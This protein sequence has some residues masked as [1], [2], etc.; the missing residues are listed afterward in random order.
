M[1]FSIFLS[2]VSA[3]TCMSLGSN[4]NE[5]LLNDTY[6]HFCEGNFS[7]FR[8]FVNCY[9]SANS[10][11]S[12][13]SFFCFTF[14]EKNNDFFFGRCPLVSHGFSGINLPSQISSPATFNENIMCKAQNRAGQ[15]CSKC[16]KG[17]AL[18]LN[19][20]MFNCVP[21]KLCHKYNWLIFII[22]HIAPVTLL[23]V[24][25]V[26]FE[27][28]LLS[29][30]AFA[31]IL[32]SQ[33]ICLQP[34]DQQNT[35]GLS[36]TPEL[37]LKI[38]YFL[39]TF[40][41]IWTMDTGRMIYSKDLCTRDNID[42][43]G[44]LMLQLLPVFYSFFLIFLT[45]VCILVCQKCH[46]ATQICKPLS[47]CFSR[48]SAKRMNFNLLLVNVFAAFYVL[49]YAKVLT[50]CLML[51]SPTYLY[52]LE[53]DRYQSVYLY[54][55]SSSYFSG[56]RLIVL[57]TFALL[58]LIVIVIFPTI[59]L[60]LYQWKKFRKTFKLDKPCFITLMDSFQQCYKDGTNGTKDCRWFSAVYFLLRIVLFTLYLMLENIFFYKY[61]M[62]LL[63]QGCLIVTVILI[64]F[65]S[66]Y[67]NSAYNKLD[68]VIML[69]GMVLLSLAIC[70][71]FP[72]YDRTSVQIMLMILFFVPFFG[73]VLFIGYYTLVKVIVGIRLSVKAWY[74]MRLSRRG[75]DVDN[76]G[77]AAQNESQPI[78]NDLTSSLPDR[79]LHPFAY[80]MK[81]H[82]SI[83]KGA[84]TKR[85]GSTD[86]R[87]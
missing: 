61:T 13:K 67:K 39:M 1:L 22:L 69:L 73:A 25:I 60:L 63:M 31:Y 58:I 14:N 45:Y 42:T 20:V 6:Q 71:S 10:T 23:F 7:N 4:F 80:L 38:Y 87:N 8:K 17:H 86:T 12:V 11:V 55:A 83:E 2:I 29:G 56:A 28:R 36:D 32:F 57:S 37:S 81:Q 41:S 65:V 19:S 82:S 21:V 44:A 64:V 68:I 46:K 62:L 59:V 78:S 33:V 50:T 43:I 51:L 48:L 27:I 53:G 34:L 49:S 66:P 72:I 70:N 15:L 75:S 47:F 54:D 76:L 24:L 77:V 16:S 52:N 79:L 30:Y 74:I 35:L 9:Y 18:S 40:Y 85:Y 3:S 26:V 5:G 84:N